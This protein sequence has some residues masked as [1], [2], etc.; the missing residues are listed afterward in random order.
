MTPKTRAPAQTSKKTGGKYLFI[1]RLHL[2][3]V[4]SEFQNEFAIRRVPAVPDSFKRRNTFSKLGVEIGNGMCATPKL[5]L[6]IPIRFETCDSN[7]LT[8]AEMRQ[9]SQIECAHCK[10]KF[11]AI[12]K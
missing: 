5:V 8:L 9:G 12:D 7:Q 4:R 2:F 11:A 6:V 3:D 10:P 1:R